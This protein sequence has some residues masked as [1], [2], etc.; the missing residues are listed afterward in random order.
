VAGSLTAS[1]FAEHP[2][3]GALE[4]R[5]DLPYGM[6]RDRPAG[7]PKTSIAHTPNTGLAGFGSI[8]LLGA[9]GLDK[10]DK[11]ERGRVEGES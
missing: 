9:E 10:W 3:G 2:R 5:Q 4:V 8:E 6:L 1:R 11:P 7:Q